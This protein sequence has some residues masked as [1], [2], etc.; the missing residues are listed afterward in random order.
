M[1][2]NPGLPDDDLSS[3]MG[4]ETLLTHD[5]VPDGPTAS[6]KGPT[7]PQIHHIRGTRY[8]VVGQTLNW[9][10]GSKMS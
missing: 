9:R 5:V 3:A 1:N 10:H 2:I 8:L 7:K 4:T 6:S